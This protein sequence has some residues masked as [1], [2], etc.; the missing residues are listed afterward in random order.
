MCSVVI[1]V[2][3]VYEFSLFESGLLFPFMRINVYLIHKQCYKKPTIRP[4]IIAK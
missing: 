4:R 2:L 3:R 1:K